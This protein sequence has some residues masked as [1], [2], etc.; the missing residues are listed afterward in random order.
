MKRFFI[1]TG[2]AATA[3]ATL[4]TSFLP[5]MSM[6]SGGM[7]SCIIKVKGFNLPEFSPFCTL[8]LLSLLII[9][10]ILF[11]NMPKAIKSAGIIL[12]TSIVSISYSY[13]FTA[14]TAFL[15]SINDL[16]IS[17]GIGAMLFP[18]SLL[19][20]CFSAWLYTA[21]DK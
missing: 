21:S 16:P 20:F 4:F 6:N 10:M 15:R 19:S 5:I 8:L 18:F 7:E 11:G 1:K 13:G 14:A 3:I 12:L 9:P 17:I 2:I